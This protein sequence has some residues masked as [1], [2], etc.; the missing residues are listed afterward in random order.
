MLEKGKFFRNFQE[1]LGSM[2]HAAH[3][4]VGKR[5]R[6]HS[7]LEAAS[8][9][10]RPI[11]SLRYCKEDENAETFLGYNPEAVYSTVRI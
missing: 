10:C 9:G 4:C 3:F 7:T 1:L 6:E 11:V 8:V 5:R 2:G